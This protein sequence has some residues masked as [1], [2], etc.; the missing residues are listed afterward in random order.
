MFYKIAS[1][2]VRIGPFFHLVLSVL[3]GLLVIFC[4]VGALIGK[5]YI[6]VV[7]IVLTCISWTSARILREA[8]LSLK[9]LGQV[10][11][12]NTPPPVDDDHS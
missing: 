10:L 2:F 6:P 7:G 3:Y 8:L 4:L 1:F 9:V 12:G 11:K 5:G